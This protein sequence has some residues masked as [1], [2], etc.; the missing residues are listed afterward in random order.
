VTELTSVTGV[1]NVDVDCV[2]CVNEH[3][4]CLCMCERRSYTPQYCTT[5]VVSNIQYIMYVEA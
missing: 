3:V 4:I 1:P 2:G 5:C